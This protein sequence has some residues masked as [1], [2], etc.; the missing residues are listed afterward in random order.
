MAKST[1]VPGG[2]ALDRVDRQLLMALQQ[3][4]RTSVAELARRVHLTPTPC[5]LRLDRLERDGYLDSFGARVN[6]ERAGFNLLAY[7]AVTLDRVAPDIFERFHRAV[8]DVDE[9]EECH[10]TAGGFDYLLKIRARS[11]ADFRRFLGV[12]LITLPGLQ[13][14]HSYFVMEVIKSQPTLNLMRGM[15]Q[16]AARTRKRARPRRGAPAHS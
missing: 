7:I 11:M 10:M 16:A 14:T 1:D 6:A 4:A 5:Q 8:Q 12:R 3:D 15:P 13:Q 9:I 2:D